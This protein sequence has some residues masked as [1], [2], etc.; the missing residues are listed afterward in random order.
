VEAAAAAADAQRVRLVAA[1]AEAARTLALRATET[2][3][4]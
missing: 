2:T 4:R 3:S 1:L